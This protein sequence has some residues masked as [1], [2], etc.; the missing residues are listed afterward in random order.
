MRVIRTILLW[1]ALILAISS[2]ALPV[3]TALGETRQQAATF[4][5][6]VATQQL[7]SR[8][9]LIHGHLVSAQDRCTPSYDGTPN[10]F[11]C[12]FDYIA[13]A[14]GAHIEW[15]EYMHVGPTGW[16]TQG[17]PWIVNSW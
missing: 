1:I 14:G 7:R 13:T 2:V 9:A 16:H 4:L 8:L 10:S 6:R 15:A 3:A 11:T 12:Y 5:H 17:K